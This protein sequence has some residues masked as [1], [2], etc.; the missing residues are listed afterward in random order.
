MAMQK[1]TFYILITILL[2]ANT[3]LFSQKTKKIELL[4][5]DKLKGGGALGTDVKRLI[6]D[7]RF[8]HEE[9]IMYCDSAYFNSKKNVLD[10][11]SNVHIE[12][13]DSLNLYGDFLRYDGNTKLSMVRNNV[14][15]IHGDA[16]LTTDSLDYDRKINRAHYFNYGKI[17]DSENDLTSIHGYYYSDTK[18][19]FAID[20]VILLNEKYTMTGDT[21]KYN[22][23]TDISYFY[24]PTTIVSDSNLIYCENGWY[25][26][27]NDVSQFNKN[28]YL[29]KG[30][31][32]LSGDSL[33]YD[34]NIGLGKA[35][36]NVEIEDTTQKVIIQGEKGTFFENT[37]I[38]TVTDSAVLMQVSDNDTLFLHA[39]TLRIKSFTDTIIYSVTD[40]LELT[41]LDSIYNFV[42]IDSISEFSIDTVAFAKDSTDTL[43]SVHKLIFT[44]QEDS[45]F[46]HKKA[47]AFN[48]VR[49]YKS[50]IQGKTD[51]LMY[52]FKDSVIQFF[53]S[54]ILWSDENQIDGEYIEMFMKNDE[55]D[56]FYIKTNAMII[57]EDDSIRYNQISGKEI[58]G[59]FK[60]NEVYLV[61]VIGNA[62]SVYYVREEA[63][64]TTQNTKG[65]LVGPNVAKGST[66]HIY[67]KNRKPA[68]IV[69]LK[70]PDGTLSPVNYKSQ[71]ELRLKNFSWQIDK[72]PTDRYD[73]FRWR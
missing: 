53:G 57:S 1:N 14:R 56:H 40:T 52:I 46:K 21:L 43:M 70:S 7:V 12:Q 50:D 6:G 72:R 18:E 55:A 59:Y 16:T 68:K 61:K 45:L 4:H 49:L 67:L 25:D 13:G 19:Y 11:F 10:A 8:K 20:S 44:Y 9:A 17:V 71:E 26:T 58:Y 5:S 24:G 42:K 2:F 33:F 27:K 69:F 54:P 64:D 65:D 30:A 63:K 38:A 62:E 51:S 36:V 31:Q 66:M 34:R 23:S 3:S 15:L 35:F 28:A 60:R 32:K 37:E 41:Y 73:I 22:T 39:D 47:F 29:L 48:K